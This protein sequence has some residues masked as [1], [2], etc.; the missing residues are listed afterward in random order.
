MGQTQVK[1]I[2]Y[3]MSWRCTSWMTSVHLQTWVGNAIGWFLADIRCLIFD[4]NRYPMSDISNCFL[5]AD[6]RCPMFYPSRYPIS[7]D[8]SSLRISMDDMP[9][10]YPFADVKLWNNT[11]NPVTLIDCFW[12]IWLSISDIY[13]Y[14]FSTIWAIIIL[15]HAFPLMA[16]TWY[17]AG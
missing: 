9:T 12:L 1:T 7:T 3:K 4:S 16:V 5:P 6:I 11:C 17:L 14:V 15:A 8:I 2:D 13:S 10:L